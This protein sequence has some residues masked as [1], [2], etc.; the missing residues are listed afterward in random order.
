MLLEK[1]NVHGM[2]YRLWEIL[3]SFISRP[4]PPGTSPAGPAL[5]SSWAFRPSLPGFPTLLPSPNQLLGFLG[6]PVGNHPAWFQ[7]L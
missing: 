2:A 1:L 3:S 4:S 6:F 7:K 5:S